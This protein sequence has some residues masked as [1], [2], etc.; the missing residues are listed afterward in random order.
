ML[1][2]VSQ[3]SSLRKVSLSHVSNPTVVLGMAAAVSTVAPQLQEVTLHSVVLH[4]GMSTALS[5]CSVLCALRLESCV[6]VN[7][8]IQRE[9]S[10]FER[11]LRQLTL[12]SCTW[13]V[14]TILDLR[15]AQM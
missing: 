7:V 13:I 10:A 14:S 5:R 9:L 6:L 11:S 2:A 3:L 15:I 1:S 8:E 12:D 4:Y